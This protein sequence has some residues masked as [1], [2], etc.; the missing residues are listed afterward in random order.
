[1]VLIAAC[2]KKD[3]EGKLVISNNTD[4]VVFIDIYGT[5]QAYENQSEKLVGGF[6]GAHST[7]ELL[8]SPLGE[9][10]YLDWYSKGG[11]LTNWLPDNMDEGKPY[12][13]IIHPQK[14][15]TYE[16]NKPASAL[17]LRSILLDGNKKE[18]KWKPVDALVKQGSSVQSVWAQASDNERKAEI[19]FHKNHHAV[20]STP[21]ESETHAYSSED[22]KTYRIADIGSGWATMGNGAEP[23]GK[24]L[25]ATTLMKDTLAFVSASDA[26][27]RTFI[28][29]K[30]P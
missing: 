15:Q 12:T 26:Q 28:F 5:K 17:P 30:Q 23:N 3:K 7:Y 6:I 24:W 8:S 27:Q 13:A 29:V 18:T 11:E 9:T 2:G 4:S 10:I 25:G 20:Y 16:I 19:V 21:G 22:R 14:Q 1:M